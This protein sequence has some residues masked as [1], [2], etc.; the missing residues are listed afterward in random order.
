MT[1]L[2]ADPQVSGIEVQD[3]AEPLVDLTGL[4]VSCA[5]T[6][7]DPPNSRWVRAGVADRLVAAD[8]A[9]PS[10]VRLLVLEGFR[11]PRAQRAIFTSYSRRLRTEFPD[12]GEDELRR[13]VSRYV[14]PLHVAPHVAGAAVDITLVDGEGRRRT[15]GTAVDATPEESRNAIAF[16]ADNISAEARAN[17]TLLAG[18]LGS[19]GL[20][21]YPTEWWHWSYGD[22]Y[23]A[24]VTG[25][26][27][28]CYGP[29]RQ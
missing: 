19:A 26:G 4:G 27:H 24:H 2:I 5:S 13:L 10:G 7:V 8:A 25:A 20:V 18:A 11:S 9:L 6:C 17:R 3:N 29:V 14:A 23:W 28:A 16:D 21:N 1:I 15:L 22:R 12:V